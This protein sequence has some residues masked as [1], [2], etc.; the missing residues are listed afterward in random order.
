M[1]GITVY[2][3]DSRIVFV[4]TPNQNNKAPEDVRTETYASAFNTFAATLVP[5]MDSTFIVYR[6]ATRAAIGF[7]RTDGTFQ[8]IECRVPD[9]DRTT[10]N[11]LRELAGLAMQI[12]DRHNPEQPREQLS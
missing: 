12:R 7:M 10:P 3:L 5:L 6:V 2:A 11:E 1:H 8:P 9:S 4:N